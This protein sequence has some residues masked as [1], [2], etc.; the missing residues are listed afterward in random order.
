MTNDPTRHL[1]EIYSAQA[2]AYADGWS[3][4]R[5]GPEDFLVVGAIGRRRP[6]A[7]A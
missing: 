1:A 2:Q 7:D 4:A 6:D 3:L 5:S